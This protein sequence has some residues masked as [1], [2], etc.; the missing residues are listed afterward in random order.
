MAPDGKSVITSV[1]STD[2]SAWI[3]D[4]NGDSSISSEGDSQAPQYSSDGRTLYFQMSSGGSQNFELWKRDLA[5]GTQE[6]VLPGYAMNKGFSVSRHSRHVAFS[7]QDKSGLSSLWVAPTD[8]HASPVKLTTSGNEDS[9]FFLPDDDLIFRSVE[10]GGNF[11]YRMKPDGSTRSKVST[12]PVLD[13]ISVSQDGRWVIVAAASNVEDISVE[14]EALPIAGGPPVTL[15]AGYCL[16]SWSVNGKFFYL[17]FDLLSPHAY[18]LPVSPTGLPKV[19]SQGIS[20]LEDIK[21]LNTI[22]EHVSSGLDAS[23]YTY[24]RQNTRRN[25]YRI[26]LP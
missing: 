25:L 17:F 6:V 7:V 10:P 18:V 13:L 2:S 19:P 20:K 11:V 23:N 16:G 9:P 4:K 26:P 14:T 22:S 24:V 5:T 8:R 12:A 3:H 15:C 21:P 1:G